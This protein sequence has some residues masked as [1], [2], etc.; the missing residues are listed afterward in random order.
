M[1]AGGYDSEPMDAHGAELEDV[2]ALYT[3][4]SN[5]SVVRGMPSPEDGGR[6]VS[7]IEMNLFCV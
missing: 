2:G 1:S 7:D 3:L 5:S 6:G 4:K